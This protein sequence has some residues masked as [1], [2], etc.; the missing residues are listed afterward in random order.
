MNCAQDPDLLPHPDLQLKQMQSRGHNNF[1]I[2]IFMFLGGCITLAVGLFLSTIYYRKKFHK[3]HAKNSQ[4][5]TMQ[6]QKRKV[7]IK[8][9]GKLKKGEEQ[10][11]KSKKWVTSSCKVREEEVANM[12]YILQHTVLDTHCQEEDYYGDRYDEHG[13]KIEKRDDETEI[14]QNYFI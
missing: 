9:P 11:G 13:V 12:E 7:K 2:L 1:S 4:R 10:R 14:L 8:N 5:S 6:P 3:L